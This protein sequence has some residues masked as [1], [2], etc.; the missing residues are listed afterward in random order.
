MGSNTIAA[1][2]YHVAAIELD[3]L[4]ADILHEDFPPDAEAW[5]PAD[6]R[7]DSGRLSTPAA[8]PLD[9]H[10]DRLAWVRR[11][12][13]DRFAAFDGAA[14][15]KVQE[16]DGVRSSPTWVLHHLAHHEAELRAQIQ[17]VITGFGDPD[18]A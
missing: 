15:D 2:L 5:F 1:L 16:N 14:F 9:R 12:L 13:E 18:F 10:I 8:E 17:T 6:V 11:R 4:C 3:W 7:D